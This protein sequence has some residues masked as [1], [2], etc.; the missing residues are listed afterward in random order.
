MNKF[1]LYNLLFTFLIFFTFNCY[2]QKTTIESD[3]AINYEFSGKNF[4]LKK[5]KTKEFRLKYPNS[6]TKYG[7]HGYVF[8]T[9]KD[10]IKNGLNNEINHLSLN[11]NEI[12]LNDSITV[13]EALETHANNIKYF[14]KNI[15]YTIK[16]INS[17]SSFNYKIEYI[18]SH[19]KIP[20]NIKRLEYFFW[21]KSKLKYVRFQMREELFAIYFNEAM[22]IINSFQFRN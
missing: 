19:N 14:E 21:S 8:L 16:K 4:K 6:W 1:I 2:A 5:F 3:S 18:R 20:S 13:E 11:K 7:A 9:P 15:E 12:I 10:I 17:E 22:L